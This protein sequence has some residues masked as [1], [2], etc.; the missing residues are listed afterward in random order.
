MLAVAL[1]TP[2]V[3]EPAPVNGGFVVPVRSGPLYAGSERI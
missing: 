1:K 3:P 2:L